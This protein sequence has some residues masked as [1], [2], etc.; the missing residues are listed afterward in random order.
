MRKLL[1]ASLLMTIVAAFFI[2]TTTVAA[3]EPQYMKSGNG[4]IYQVDA[5]YYDYVN[6]KIATIKINVSHRKI[7]AYWDNNTWITCTV[8]AL[9]NKKGDTSGDVPKDWIDLSK[10]FEYTAEIN[11]HKV[12]FDSKETGY[13]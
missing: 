11:N 4:S 7:V 5:Y 2:P 9:S 3:P 6:N 13:Y 12:F 8:K 1:I 10:R